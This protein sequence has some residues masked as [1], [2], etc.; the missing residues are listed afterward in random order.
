VK[1][2]LM[3]VVAVAALA[4][5]NASGGSSTP[6]AR[7]PDQSL[8]TWLSAVVACLQDRGWSDTAEDAGGQGITNDTLP[9]S[10]R[11]AFS[12]D[13]AECE[14]R[15]GPQPG[16]EAVTP[17]RAG[18]IYDQLVVTRQCLEGLGYSISDPPSRN[19][20]IDDY[21]GGRAPWHPYLDLP[22]LDAAALQ[23]AT[24]ECPQP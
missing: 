6:E 2:V 10:Q 11:S 23:T 18:Q 20:F 3:I 7:S 14:T 16:A 13:L 22:E 17:Q 12:G 24:T 5:C 19:T 21:L 1:R 8:T 15:A 4:G 9:E